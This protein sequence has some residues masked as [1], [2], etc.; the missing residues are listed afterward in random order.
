MF[1]IVEG[2]GIVLVGFK[3]LIVKLLKLYSLCFVVLIKVVLVKGL[4]ILM[5]LK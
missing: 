5:S 4:F 3:L 2:L 1:R